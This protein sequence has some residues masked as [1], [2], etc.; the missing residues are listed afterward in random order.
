M[1]ASNAQYKYLSDQILKLHLTARDLDERL[2]A[3]PPPPK[4]VAV[5]PTPPVKQD[6]GKNIYLPGPATAFFQVPEGLETIFVTM[7]GGGGA[8]TPGSETEPGV[9]GG[10][11][12]AVSRRA[13][14]VVGG[15]GQLLLSAGRG[16]ENGYL[17]DGTESFVEVLMKDGSRRVLEA[18]GGLTGTEATK[19]AGLGASSHFHTTFSGQNGNRPHSAIEAG[20][21]GNSYF[22]SGGSGGGSHY[23]TGKLCSKGQD[24]SFGSGGGGSLAG[25]LPG[26][27]GSGFIVI[28]YSFRS[29]HAQ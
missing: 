6:D 12:E 21:G 4:P 20:A 23:E 2:R 29:P 7:S 22:S 27:G 24:G 28:E 19:G 1:S 13:L 15:T 10:A 14:S 18:K 9:G 16:G 25:S 11:A 8:G 26:K 3:I 17:P 5:D